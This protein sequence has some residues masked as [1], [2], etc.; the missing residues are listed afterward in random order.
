MTTYVPID[1]HGRRSVVMQM[2]ETGEVLGWTRLAND[3]ETLVA[4]VLKAG[5]APEVAIEATYVW[6][7]AV[8]ALAAAGANVHL[9]APARVSAF[10]GRR[11]KNDQRDCQLLGDLTTRPSGAGCPRPVALS[12]A[13]RTSASFAATKGDAFARYAIRMLAKAPSTASRVS[14]SLSGQR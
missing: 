13:A 14:L 5:E 11:V 6:Y 2:T 10:D 4:E 12:R 8:D 1:L 3:P 7:W 9:V